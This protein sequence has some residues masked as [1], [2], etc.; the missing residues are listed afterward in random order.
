MRHATGG[1]GAEAGRCG[2]RAGKAA[3]TWED[4]SI[5]KRRKGGDR[6]FWQRDC[7]KCRSDDDIGSRG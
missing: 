6:D 2:R 7:Q 1:F 5:V 3:H 4:Q